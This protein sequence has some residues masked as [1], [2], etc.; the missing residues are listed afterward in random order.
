[1]NFNPNLKLGDVITNQELRTIFACGM[2]GGMRRSKKT[3][4]LVIVSDHTKGL[5]E[6]KWHGDVL[7]YTGM[8]KV[9]D[10]D[11]N[12]SQNRTLNESTHNG[13]SVFLFEVFEENR[14]IY[15][16][17][18]QLIEKPYQQKQI[19]ATGT[20][21]NVWIFPLKSVTDQRISIDKKLL[22]CNYQKKEKKIKKLSDQELAQKAAQLQSFKPSIRSTISQTYERNPYVTEYA[23]RRAN[24]ICELCEQEAPFKT[25]Q[26]DPYLETH[27]I[28]WLCNGGSDTIENTVALCPNCHKKM[29]VVDDLQ[30]KAKLIKIDKHIEN[31]D[32]L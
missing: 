29:H 28:E 11:I 26:N 5:Y 9:G 19:D 16:G 31:I 8:G 10:Q 13:V 15:R 20:L 12:A 4:T 1:M 6:D 2:M 32:L 14:Y 17:Q 24:G 30:D 18:V 21:R 27:H 7:H 22:D 23:K 25:K 3:N